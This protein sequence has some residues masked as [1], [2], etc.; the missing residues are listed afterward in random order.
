VQNRC[1]GKHCGELVD[2]AKQPHRRSVIPGLFRGQG[3]V[4][5]V[6]EGVRRVFEGQTDL[7][8]APGVGDC[9][10]EQS[11]RRDSAYHR[12]RPCMI[13]KHW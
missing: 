8:L 11:F 5:D 3:E 1:L 6:R 2:A 13:H 10:P 9:S 12:G 4:P 7:V